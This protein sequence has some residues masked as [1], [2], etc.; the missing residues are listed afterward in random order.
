[1][2]DYQWFMKNELSVYFHPSTKKI[3]FE[4]LLK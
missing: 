3:N 1:M 4:Q 2:I